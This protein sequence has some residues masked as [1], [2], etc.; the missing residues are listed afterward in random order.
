MGKTSSTRW[1]GALSRF[2]SFPLARGHRR[3]E[4]V[5]I[6]I[7]LLLSLALV[8]FALVAANS[9]WLCDD[10]FFSFRPALHLV[11]G[12]G[13]RSNV[14]ERVQGFTNP[15]W[16]LAMAGVFFAGVGDFVGAMAMSLAFSVAAAHLLTRHLAPN[17]GAAL[18]GVV[19]LSSSKAFVDYST[20]GLENPMFHMIYAG[21]LVL[22]LR[23]DH[24]HRGPMMLGLSAS[25][26]VMTRPD[27]ALLVIPCLLWVWLERPT[28]H[29][30]VALAVGGL[31]LLAW[32]LFSL[33]YYGS[34]VPCTAITKLGG[35]GLDRSF[36][37]QRG[38]DYLV[39]SLHWDRVTMPVILLAVVAT[40]AAHRARELL[41]LIGIVAYLAYVVWVGGDFMVGRFTTATFLGAVVLLMR[42]LQKRPSLSLVLAG[43]ALMASLSSPR[44]PLRSGP[45][46]IE[47]S[48]GYEIF[49]RHNVADERM[50]HHHASG[51]RRQLS[52]GSTLPTRPRVETESHLVAVVH[53]GYQ[54]YYDGPNMHAVQVQGLTDPLVA[55]MP[56]SGEDLKRAGHAY[57]VIPRGYLRSLELGE[58]CIDDERVAKLYDD[59]V[60]VTRG[61]LWPRK[62]WA[63]MWR[64]NTGYYSYLREE[65][66]AKEIR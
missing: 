30:L 20:S 58:N 51:I 53:S 44:S 64:L 2:V 10:C 45:N 50:F 25:L 63:A 39:D 28:V 52:E 1:S 46:Y 3:R 62:R 49:L 19:L 42:S 61:P 56:T 43:T 27:L 8:G 4:R 54:P 6:S 14:L 16:T 21:F 65:E 13:L 7:R 47:E 34:L 41:V 15:L 18:L 37:I 35:T 12:Y 40:L 38:W 17:L 59:I 24:G 23:A 5:P 48:D 29:S 57:R 31:P 36:L 66:I 26:L 60:L 9:T 22:F 33:V 55:R 32:E 11:E